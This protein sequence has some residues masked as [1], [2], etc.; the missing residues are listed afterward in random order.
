MSQPESFSSTVD[1]EKLV[2]DLVKP[3]GS[4]YDETLKKC[5]VMAY[6][7]GEMAN[8][9]CID[10]MNSPSLEIEIKQDDSPVTMVDKKVNAFLIGQ[11][12]HHFIQSNNNIR[13]IGEEGVSTKNKDFENRDL[14]EGLVFYVDPID[15]TRDFISNNGEWAVMIGLCKDG[16]PVMGCIYC[17]AQDEMFYAIKSHGTFVIRNKQNL[18]KVQCNQFNPDDLST[19]KCLISRNNYDQMTENI[20]DELG[21][22]NRVPCGSFGRKVCHLVA[23][24]GDLYFNTSCKSSYWDSA[25]PSIILEEA[26]GCLL[27]KNGESVFFNGH[28]TANDY[29]L[30]CCPISVSKKV[31]QVLVKHAGDRE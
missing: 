23:G 30:F 14:S 15:G 31:L 9:F 22:Q 7:A 13:I 26:G 16:R 10:R 24:N 6:Q 11:L 25:A 4:E 19:T 17:A 27:R 8:N 20:L 28:R 29:I 21:V 3:F 18:S 12:E 1:Y 2:N 5:L